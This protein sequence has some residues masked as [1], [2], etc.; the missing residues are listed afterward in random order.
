MKP[1]ELRLIIA[2]GESIKLE[3]KSDLGPLPDA[4]LLEV[5]VCLANHQGGQILI[6]VDGQITGLHPTH[7][8]HPNALAAFIAGRTVLPLAAEVEFIQLTEGT[9]GVLNIPAACQPTATSDGKL[10]VRFLDVH[11]KPGCRPLYPYE[12][13]SWKAD[14]GQ[15]DMTAMPVVEATW[16]DLDPLEFARLRRMVEDNRGDSVLLELPDEGIAKTLGLVVNENGKLRPTLGGLL[17]AGKETALRKY[18]P[19][20]EVAFQVLHGS[21]VKVNEF[22]R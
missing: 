3:F 12:L 11:N 6:G 19:A 16:E 8:P 14:R 13:A 2:A 5:C 4:E 15:V 22:R 1:E 20:H 17:V 7:L 10:I 21:D 18:L 9:V